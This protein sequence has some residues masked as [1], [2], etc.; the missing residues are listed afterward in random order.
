MT[1]SL[2]LALRM[3][4]VTLFALVNATALLLGGGGGARP[5]LLACGVVA[6]AAAMQS[7]LW[8]SDGQSAALLLSLPPLLPMTTGSLPWLLGPLGGLLL[9]ACELNSASWESA[10]G[11]PTG[12]LVRRRLA[13]A[14]LLSAAGIAAS[15]AVVVAAGAGPPV[16]G[17]AALIVAAAALAGL[18]TLIFGRG[19][20]PSSGAGDARQR[21]RG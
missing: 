11:A 7:A 13:A 18:G 16:R 9:L 8:E 6:V 19:H 17:T 12:S 4:S 5:V 20:T 10:S 1:A 14:S 21:D 2:R 15:V 3:G